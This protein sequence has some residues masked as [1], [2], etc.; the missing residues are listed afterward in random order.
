MIRRTILK[1]TKNQ[2]NSQKKIK[3][4]FIS[5]FKIY[6]KF[7]FQLFHCLNWKV[8]LTF[9]QS[10]LRISLFIPQKRSLLFDSLTKD[11]AVFLL[12]FSSEDFSH[13]NNAIFSVNE[14]EFIKRD[15]FLLYMNLNIYKNFSLHL[16]SQ[17]C[18]KHKRADVKT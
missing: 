12:D 5:L 1:R 16:A 6:G 13:K 8:I 15:F 9:L 10:S 17:I 4:P 3:F 7:F 11:G 18:A 14:R 2:F